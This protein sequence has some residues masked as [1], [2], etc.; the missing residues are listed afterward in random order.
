VDDV[1]KLAGRTDHTEGSTQLLMRE[2]LNGQLRIVRTI[3]NAVAH[4]N[5]QLLATA[6]GVDVRRRQV[7]DITDI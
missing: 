6:H 3:D 7:E 1:G 4:D 5:S 2:F